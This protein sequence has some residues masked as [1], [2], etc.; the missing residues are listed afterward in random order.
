MRFI[1]LRFVT[2]FLI[3]VSSS[4]QDGDS[5]VTSATRPATQPPTPVIGVAFATV[6]PTVARG[7]GTQIQAPTPSAPPTEMPKATPESYIVRAGDTLVGIAA[8]RGVGLEEIMALNPDIQP[9][10]LL[11]GQEIIVPSRP[12]PEPT[13]QAAADGPI[14]VDIAGLSMYGSAT[15]GAWV[16]G[17][18]VN[19][20]LGAVELV[21][22][23][24][25]LLSSEGERL[26]NQTVWVTPVTIPS[27][28]RAPFGVLFSEVIPVD[29][30]ADAEIVAGQPVNDLGNRYLDL[31]VIDA[32]VTIGHSPVE[33][34][35][36]I[37]NQ[38]QFS[39]GQISIVTTFYD[40]QGLV[41]GY[42]ELAL[43]GVIGAGERRPF[44]FFALP[45][46]GEVD[47]AGYAIQA[48]LVQ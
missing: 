19:N 36:Q 37:T 40:D 45:P 7:G 10:L 24:V 2:I 9:E 31:A 44:A 17:E 14:Q 46:G 42:H 20:G 3:L 21:Q 12:E 32:E 29:V 4:C 39:A 34:S 8:A 6:T 13:V 5:P 48:T 28:S 16:V 18:V 1:T 11:V 38:G 30:A 26:A 47:S 35:G 41:T 15:G 25:T 33:V 22:V 43:D 27:R 23:M